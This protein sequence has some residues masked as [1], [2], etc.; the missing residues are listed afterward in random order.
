MIRSAVVLSPKH[1]CF[2]HKNARIPLSSLSPFLCADK[3]PSPVYFVYFCDRISVK[4][5]D[6]KG[7]KDGLGKRWAN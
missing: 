7:Q 6:Q 2:Y 1:Y 3:E 4:G 5:K